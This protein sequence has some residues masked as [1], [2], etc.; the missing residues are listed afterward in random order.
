LDCGF[1]SKQFSNQEFVLP[2]TYQSRQGFE[3]KH[4]LTFQQ[5]KDS[6][7]ERKILAEIR[8]ETH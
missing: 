5:F 4:S 3:S 1:P 8:K 6:V 7:L 2:K